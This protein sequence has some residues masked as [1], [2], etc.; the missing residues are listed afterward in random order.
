VAAAPLAAYLTM[1][2]LAGLLIVTAWVM[3]EPHRWPERLR[4]SAGDRFLLFLTFGLTV[5]SSL[6]V[7]IAVG[8]TVGLAQRLLR[9]ATPPA[10]EP[11]PDG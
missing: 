2:A 5:L 1:P 11:A 4:A 10:D 3:S 8:T 9:R 7:A 6:T